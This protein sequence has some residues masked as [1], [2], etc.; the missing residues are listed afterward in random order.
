MANL[1]VVLCLCTTKEFVSESNLM[2][3]ANLAR[4]LGVSYILLIEPRA[5][6]RYKDI[7]VGLAE[8]QIEILEDFYLK[9][10]FDKAYSEMPAVSYHGY[11]QRRIGCFGGGNRY[12][13]INTEGNFQ[14]CPF[15]Q[16]QFGSAL[17]SS[18]NKCTAK[19]KSNG[20]KPFKQAVL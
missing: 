9:M 11:H 1:V 7:D 13:Y 3:Y 17:S 14:V 10:N 4:R 18:I 20:C 12:V 5:V 19:M 8:H 15:C 16:Q 2:Q 6:G